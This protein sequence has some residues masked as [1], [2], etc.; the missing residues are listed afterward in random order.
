M[1]SI[2]RSF[3]FL[4]IFLALLGCKNENQRNATDS[5]LQNVEN[6][7]T[8]IDINNSEKPS[9]YLNP[10]DDSQATKIILDILS[11]HSDW[12]KIYFQDSTTIVHNIS[13]L[14]KFSLKSKE[15]IVGFSYT[16]YEDNSCNECSGVL[17]FFEFENNTGWTLKKK[18]IGKVSAIPQSKLSI[19]PL[20]FDNYGILISR[21]GNMQGE[22]YTSQDLYAFI[23]DDFV[24]ILE[25]SHDYP[26]TSE[27][28]IELK[29]HERDG[30]FYLLVE[31]TEIK[32][33]S[34][35]P[36]H[37]EEESSEEAD[38]VITK[39]YYNFNGSK[40]EA[41]LPSQTDPSLTSMDRFIDLNSMNQKNN[42]VC[43]TCNGSGIQVCPL[44]GGT[45]V[46]NMG[47]ECSCV[48][49]Y[50]TEIASGHNPNH[51]PKQWTCPSCSGTGKY[52]R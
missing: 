17:S 11:K 52:I 50:K 18:D 24:S 46:N 40:Y 41:F 4:I 34:S 26:I 1:K 2:K 13:F 25:L 20:S 30:Y 37:P 10:W 3:G 21:S 28:K 31:E 33:A 6:S 43:P 14:P 39:T 15:I 42:G 12:S 27:F 5:S 47:I 32:N 7:S 35:D 45:G 48:R 29:K 8:G 19:Y 44:C 22:C 23:K 9:Y 49:T 36:F 38:T 51:P 16:D